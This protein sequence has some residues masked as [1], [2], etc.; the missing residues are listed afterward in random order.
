MSDGDKAKG[1]RRRGRG[2]GRGGGAAA[3]RALRTATT[4]EHSRQIE[5]KIGVYD[6]VSDEGLALIENNAELVLE[7]IGI[8][9]RDDP[10]SLKLWRDAGA[11]VDGERVR[12]PRGLVRSLLKACRR[13]ASTS[14]D[15]RRPNCVGKPVSQWNR[16]AGSWT[17]LL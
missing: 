7:E 16:L 1:G 2:G 15:T 11:D 3:R 13:L 17:T 12:C 10:E 5:R 6:L 4:V 14:F 9:F 8:D